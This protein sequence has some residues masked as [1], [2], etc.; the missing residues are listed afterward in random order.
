MNTYKQPR[1]LASVSTELL[2]KVPE[3]TLFFW[4][5]KI[6]CTTVG[7][8]AADFL[9]VNLN[10]GLTGTSIVVGILLAISLI[11]QFKSNKYI[12]SIYWL[13]VGL[14]SVFGTLV[15]DNLTDKIGVPLETS[16]IIFS[17]LLGI[18]FII[19]YLK[20]KTL[21]VHAILTTR[22]EIFYWL[23]IL[24]TFALGTASGDLM[25]E[26]LALG[27]LVTGLI[28][29]SV[30]AITAVA[31]RLKLNSVLSFWIIYIMTRPLGASIGD[32]LSQSTN[33][34]GLGLGVTITSVIFIAGIIGTVT[35]LTFTKKDVIGKKIVEEVK[36]DEH[37]GGLFQTVVVGLI[38]LVVGGVEYHIQKT[39]L[40]VSSID[41]SNTIQ[42][43][44]STILTSAIGDLSIFSIITQDTLDKLNTGDQSGATT[45][46][47]DLE[48][49]WD[50]AQARLK[51][52]DKSKWTEI[53]VKIDTV[54]RELRAVHPNITDEKSALKTLLMVLN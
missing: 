14:V 39:K 50:N 5:I 19:W 44:N 22:R 35:Y 18:T 8:T 21:S 11:L 43:N 16:T 17:I 34:G 24:F 41:T 6:L 46:I 49:E 30:I 3:I 51:P 13:T 27:Y 2:N 23:A 15:T 10:F 45:R 48:Y 38:F 42:S 40:E 9:N 26:G 28:V 25:S 33:H 36:E 53:D 52:R 37:K 54:L 32:F 20:E 1:H 7:E 12:P 31:W 4:V 47:G 29:S